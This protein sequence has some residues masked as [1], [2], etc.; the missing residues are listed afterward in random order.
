M[1]AT[2]TN[3]ERL[4][5]KVQQQPDILPTLFGSGYGQYQIQ[6]KNF[7][8]SF[9]LHMLVVAGGLVSSWWVALHKQ[10]IKASITQVFAPGDIAEYVLPPAPDK[11][12]GG[13]GG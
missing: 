1:S 6:R 3:P 11:A 2:A 4:Q 12:G 9:V 7:L 10:E 8:F 5:P 13:G